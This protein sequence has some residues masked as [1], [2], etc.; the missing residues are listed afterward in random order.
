M[1]T[2][3]MTLLTFLAI[4]SLIVL[5]CGVFAPNKVGMLVTDLGLHS[6]WWGNKT[7]AFYRWTWRK[8][9][10]ERIWAERIVKE[11]FHRA[12]VWISSE[13][14]EFFAQQ[15]YEFS[16]TQ[17]VDYLQIVRKVEQ[18]VKRSDLYNQSVQKLIKEIL[19][20]V[21]S[22]S[23]SE[24]ARLLGST[25][26]DHAGPRPALPHYGI[27]EVRQTVE[28]LASLVLVRKE[29]D[30][31]GG[32]LEERML[33][34]IQGPEGWQH[35]LHLFRTHLL[36]EL[37]QDS[38]KNEPVN[39][40][41]A[42]SVRGGLLQDF[43]EDIL[44]HTGFVETLE[45]LITQNRLPMDKS[46]IKEVED[47]LYTW[48]FDKDIPFTSADH[49]RI[50]FF[51]TRKELSLHFQEIILKQLPRDFASLSALLNRFPRH[52]VFYGENTSARDFAAE[53]YGAHI[54]EM[55]SV[56]AHLARQ[57]DN[58]PAALVIP[59]ADIKTLINEKIAE[60]KLKGIGSHQNAEAIELTRLALGDM[61]DQKKKRSIRRRKLDPETADGKGWLINLAWD[62]KS[63]REYEIFQFPPL[64]T[65]TRFGTDGFLELDFSSDRKE[66]KWQRG[67]FFKAVLDML[68]W[69]LP[70]LQTG[71]PPDRPDNPTDQLNPPPDSPNRRAPRWES[72]PA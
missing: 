69:K 16:Q 3:F 72:V 70:P 55:L 45:S 13:D 67:L 42:A 1:I 53:Q 7:T 9:N 40:A 35:W 10:R 30:P 34:E 54:Q 6:P 37:E 25:T 61:I 47:I 71:D 43:E 66:A 44:D 32:S 21:R 58:P 59:A 41:L 46:R 11:A 28:R 2:L 49:R 29:P 52:V 27:Q 50:R 68:I 36:L 63:I 57:D 48:Q 62:E 65:Y 38:K 56:F 18:I 24:A 23:E 5:F 8:T 33:S 20:R 60:L 12:K 4:V 19:R 31:G 64:D 22:T 39:K 17:K 51:L 14:C 26:G 15:C